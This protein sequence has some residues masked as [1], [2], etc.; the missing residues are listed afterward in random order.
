MSPLELWEDFQGIAGELASK[1]HRRAP[2]L[3]RD[4]LRQAS[5]LAAWEAALAYDPARNPNWRAFATLRVKSRLVNEVWRLNFWGYNAHQQAKYRG[6]PLPA[7]RRPGG[8]D[9]LPARLDATAED[10]DL[11][12]YLLSRIP[13]GRTQEA[14]RRRWREGLSVTAIARQMALGTKLV[15][16]MLTNARRLMAAEAARLKAQWEAADVVDQQAA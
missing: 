8:L 10:H 4:D 3:D 15:E 9:W 1:Q 16:F 14:A 2:Q 12:D 5:L 7:V 6:V 13:N 11:F